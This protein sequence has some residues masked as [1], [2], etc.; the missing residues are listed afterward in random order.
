VALSRERAVF[1]QNIANRREVSA[2]TSTW[3]AARNALTKARQTLAIAEAA[4]NRERR[5]LGQNLNNVAPIQAARAQYVQAQSDLRAARSTLALFKSAPGQ[6][7]RVPIVA[8]IAGVVQER[9]R[10]EGEVLDADAQILTIADLSSVHVDMFVPERDISRLRIGAP[11]KIQVEAVPGRIFPGRIELLHTEIDPK[12]RTIEAHAEI[13]NPN[14]TL[15]FGM[16]ARGHIITASRTAAVSVPVAAIQKMEG[17][18]VVFVPGDDPSTFLA[19]EV[20]AGATEGGRTVIKAG[21][22]AGEP[23]VVEGAFMVKAQAM[24]AELG[25]EH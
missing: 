1:R 10:A 20:D 15:R 2:A 14:R 25:H 21:L 6:S 22:K 19:R 8:P 18:N 11:V 7:A 24:K 13:P 23:V 4:S 12:T 3:D 17:K 16:S 5:I 9:E